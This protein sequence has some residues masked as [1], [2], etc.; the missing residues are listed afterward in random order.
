MN[1]KILV[2]VGI[3]SAVLLI[4]MQAY[5]ANSS[6]FNF[7]KIGT[8]AKALGMGGAYSAIADGKDAMYW[9]AAGL[10]EVRDSE[11]GTTYMDY[12]VGIKS[13][14]VSYALPL[15]GKSGLGIALNYLDYGKIQETS[16]EDITGETLSEFSA[17]DLAY[18][19]GYG[20]KIGDRLAVGLNVGM[21]KEKIKDYEAQGI[22]GD[23][24]LKYSLVPG[25]IELGLVGKNI[26]AQTKAFISEKGDLPTEYHLGVGYKLNEGLVL[27]LEGVNDSNNSSVRAG[28]EYNWRQMVSLRMGFNSLIN[29]DLKTGSSKDSTTGFSGGLGLAYRGI[30]IDY[31]YLPFNE[32]GDVH[33]MS[34]GLKFGAVAPVVKA[35]KEDVVIRR[36]SELVK[37]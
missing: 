5:G 21:V 37:N 27:G 32:L 31:S 12:V 10:S 15:N 13:G 4:A 7:L 3:V 20:T 18:S 33:R 9:N 22:M 16:A 24:G 14:Y 8:G 25:K 6:G 11:I 29:S 30:N 28:A 1:R 26:G 23:A 34:L 35:K 19:I 2:S 17:Y 36:R